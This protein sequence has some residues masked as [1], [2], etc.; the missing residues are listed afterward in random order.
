MT[1]RSHDG[2]LTDEQADKTMEKIVN[3]LK[4]HGAELR[5]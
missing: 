5:M 4:E 3:A 2:T 1:L